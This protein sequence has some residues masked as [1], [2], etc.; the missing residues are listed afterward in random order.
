M[1]DAKEETTD[2]AT[3]EHINLKV[4]FGAG[5]YIL[6]VFGSTIQRA[7]SPY[8]LIH[9]TP[10]FSFPSFLITSIQTPFPP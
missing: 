10:F 1:A 5:L 6:L 9:F 8:P 2:T 4:G 7:H 3:P